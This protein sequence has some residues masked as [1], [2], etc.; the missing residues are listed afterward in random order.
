MDRETSVEFLPRTTSQGNIPSESE[1][2]KGS[3]KRELFINSNISE[4]GC[5][6]SAHTKPGFR[7]TSVFIASCP[8]GEQLSKRV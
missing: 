7:E 3:Q 8:M 2:E 4:S 1:K 6:K 5:N